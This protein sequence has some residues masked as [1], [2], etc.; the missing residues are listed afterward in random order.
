MSLSGEVLGLLRLMINGNLN[1]LQRVRASTAALDKLE[2]FLEKYLE[3]HLERRFNMK[4]T[5][6]VL[7]KM[8]S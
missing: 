2:T 4:N 5:I 3:Y 1:T 6:R 8:L 7:K